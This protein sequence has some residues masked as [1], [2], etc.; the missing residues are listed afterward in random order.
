[1]KVSR[2]SHTV[3]CSSSR[4]SYTNI[5]PYRTSLDNFWL[6]LF[7]VVS[8]GTMAVPTFTGAANILA[9]R[10]AGAPAVV[11]D[12][13]GKK[14]KK[15]GKDSAAEAGQHSWYTPGAKMFQAAGKSAN[16]LEG[17][18]KDN[19]EGRTLNPVQVSLI[20]CCRHRV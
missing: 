14:G 19:G 7:I 5:S 8:F 20:V 15:S 12:K 2:K 17:K 6:A 16:D 18:E 9:D 13:K 1:M 10:G 3:P 4:S 11:S